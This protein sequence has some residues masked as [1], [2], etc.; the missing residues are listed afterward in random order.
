MTRT[1]W[2]GTSWKM[3]KLIDEA[4]AYVDELAPLD[5]PDGM[6]AFVLPPHT[7]LAA[8]RE[9]LPPASPILLGAQNAHWAEAG[10]YTG[11]VSMAMVR[12]A[13]AALVEI[14]HSERREWF[15]ETDRTVA[16]KTASAVANGL[17]PLVCVGEPGTVRDRGD[18]S[19]FV[20]D[21]VGEALSGLTSAEV[22]RVLIAYEPVW[23]IGRHG[24]AATLAEITPVTAVIRTLLTGRADGGQPGGVLYGGSV[25]LDNAADL[26][27][28]PNVDGLFVGRTGL[29]AASFVTLLELCARARGLAPV[30]RLPDAS[31]AAS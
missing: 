16:A 30:R 4:R 7:A 22:G 27:A 2:V 20:A 11:E 19:T 1:L 21:Q 31:P 24:R 17:V 8:V 14:G 12:D 3:N 13:G 5:L 10:A 26:V 23:A 9:R 18:A 28:D 6:Q 15:G 25:D 29:R